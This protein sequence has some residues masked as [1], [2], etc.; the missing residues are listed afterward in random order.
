MQC[1]KCGLDL[2]QGVKQC[3][4]CGVINEF[5]P[6]QTA[7]R[8]IKP[9]TIAIVV[10][11][12]IALI[13]I[14]LAAVFAGRGPGDITQSPG[15]NIPPGDVTNVPAGAPSGGDLTNVPPGSPAPPAAAP[16]D[17]KKP[18]PPQEVVDYLD[19]VKKVEKHRQMLLK[20]TGEALML[21]QGGGQAASLMAMI[22]MATDPEGK[23]AQ[24]PLASSKAELARQFTNWKQTL[25]Y[26]D[27][28]AAP[29]QCREFS[30]AYRQVL[31]NETVT[32]GKIAV[33]FND[34]NVMDPNDMSKLLRSLQKMKGDPS[35]QEKIDESADNADKKLDALVANY[36]MEKPF[37]VPREKQTSGSIMGF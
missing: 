1:A 26:Y 25:D 6:Q 32:I 21:G 35:I 11:A 9:I 19:F 7:K 28:R 27:R 29:A 36:D 17:V 37:D 4:K 15:G 18:K 12:L 16:A 33:D 22:D 3:P 2:P 34:V 13:S 24:D 14:G 8:K 5:A 10:L 23:A 30:G 31:Y 20:D